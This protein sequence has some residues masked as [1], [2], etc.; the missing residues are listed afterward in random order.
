V[1]RLAT[2]AFYRSHGTALVAAAVI[3]GSLLPLSLIYRSSVT[4]HSSTAVCVKIHRLDAA[5]E[6]IID[7]AQPTRAQLAQLSYYRSHPA[8][9]DAT[10]LQA[11]RAHARELRL[12]RSADCAVT[13]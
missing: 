7:E 6:T 13:T 8:E 5:L 10:L 9:L 12:L 3:A 11:R 4:S 1:K 2:I